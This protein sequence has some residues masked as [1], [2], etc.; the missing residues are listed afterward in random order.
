MVRR[1]PH[2]AGPSR[3]PR[4]DP[5][6][7]RA[8]RDRRVARRRRA[9]DRTVSPGSSRPIAERSVCDA[10]ACATLRHRQPGAW[11]DGA[12]A[13]RP[14]RADLGHAARAS[15]LS[16]PGSAGRAAGA[17]AAGHRAGGIGEERGDGRRDR[18]RV[19]HGGVGVRVQGLGQIRDIGD[20]CAMEPTVGGCRRGDR[21]WGPH[22]AGAG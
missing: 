9:R 21:D 16:Q 11:R 20:R 2:R 19:A 17:G 12:V 7:C 6:G 3:A 18:A 22:G 1:S 14:R 13:G 15:H 5:R 8:D 10:R 4:Q